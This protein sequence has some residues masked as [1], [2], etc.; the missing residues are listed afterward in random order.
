MPRRL[1]ERFKGR[2]FWYTPLNEPRITAWYCGRL[3][4]WPPYARG[5]RGFVAVMLAIARGIVE[6]VR[7]LRSI[8]PA[9]VPVHVDATDLYEAEHPSLAEEAQR[10]Q[11]IVFLA[12]DLVSGRVDAAHP[13]MAWLL[14]NRRERGGT[15]I[16]SC[17]RRSTCRSSASI[18]TR[19]S[20]TSAS[21]ATRPGAIASVMPYA[22]G[23]LVV[24]LGRLYYERYGVPLFISETA[25]L[26]SV[27]RRSA[28]STIR[29]RRRGSC[30]PR[31]FRSSDYTW[32]PMFALVAWAYRQGRR[33]PH[34][35][36]AQMGLWDIDPSSATL[37]R[38]SR[39]H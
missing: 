14:A 35:Y 21:G 11:E 16:A 10:R 2:V 8:D 6:T 23:D 24:T 22:S 13:L 17:D 29:S 36:F 39:R 34:A 32:W 20:P 27:K 9:I 19:C 3:G 1:A 5:W 31:A 33:E 38:S 25:S 12:L 15:R 28:G 37:N 26:G 30:A 7:A 18:S 4:W